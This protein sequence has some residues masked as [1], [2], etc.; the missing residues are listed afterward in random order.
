MTRIKLCGLTRPEDIA[1]AN[2]LQPGN[3]SGI[4]LPV[5][6]GNIDNARIQQARHRFRC[7]VH[8]HAHGLDPGGKLCF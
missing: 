1:A 3:V 5:E 8:E 4:L 2:A 7:F 6:L